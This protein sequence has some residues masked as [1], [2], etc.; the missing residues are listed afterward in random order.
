MNIE[1]TEKAMERFHENTWKH[2]TLNECIISLLRWR[3]DGKIIL[4][5]DICEKSFFFNEV[6]KNGNDCM[7]GGII[8]HRNWVKKDDG[9]FVQS[10]NPDCG[11]YSIHT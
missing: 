4:M 6:D 10:D 8:F 5:T 1:F 3:G 9:T 2:S 11:K 7:K